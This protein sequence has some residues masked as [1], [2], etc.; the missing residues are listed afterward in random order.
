MASTDDTKQHL[1]SL[2]KDIKFAMLTTEDGAHL[3]S[4]PM[5][6]SQREFDGALW[7]F[8]RASAPKV[9]EVRADERVNVSFS[10]P[11][12]Q[13]YVS[14][15]GTAHVVRD[16]AEIDAHW[17]KSVAAWFPKGRADPDIALLRVDVEQA[18]YWDAPSSSMV[19]GFQ[20]AKALLTGTT[21]NPGENE[22][23]TL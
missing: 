3:R 20:Q 22:K 8:T 17:S 23:V 7:F 1:W 10:A 9:E 12:D 18:E 16:A 19:R 6:T 2:I 11:D 14:M 5:A 21:P 13:T 15:S 4:R